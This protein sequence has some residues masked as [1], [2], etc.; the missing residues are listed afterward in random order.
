MG[1][2]G[3]FKKKLGYNVN[4]RWQERFTYEF[5]FDV[6]PINNIGTLDASASYKL[7][8]MKSTIQVGGSNLTNSYNTQIWGGPQ[9]GRMIFAGILVDIK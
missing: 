6:G 7:D 9:L 3:E 4:Y 8:K 5:P 2:D 1:V